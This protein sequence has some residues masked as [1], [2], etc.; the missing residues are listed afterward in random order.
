M[1]KI[2]AC[3]KARPFAQICQNGRQ[4]RNIKEIPFPDKYFAK[5]FEKRYEATEEVHSYG[6]TLLF[7]KTISNYWKVATTMQQKGLIPFVHGQSAAW[8]IS[9]HVLKSLG[10][11]GFQLLRHFN[12]SE[13]EIKSSDV[14]ERI[15][16]ILEDSKEFSRAH[17][18]K[19]FFTK[20]CI[21]DHTPELRKRLLSVTLGFF[22]IDNKESPCSFAIGGLYRGAFTW[23]EGAS[24]NQNILEPGECKE[25]STTSNIN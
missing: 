21:L 1:F 9:Q 10:F 18:F 22:H 11:K 4:R 7:P 5:T 6:K 20:T 14:M 23:I 13:S 24:G 2:S 19:S 25:T 3:S 17:P 12:A 15:S 16:K 8:Y